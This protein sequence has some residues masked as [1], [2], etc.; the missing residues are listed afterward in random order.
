MQ[1]SLFEDVGP[2]ADP[3]RVSIAKVA[4]R[5]AK[6]LGYTWV[7]ICHQCRGRLVILNTDL[8]KPRPIFRHDDGDERCA[9]VAFAADGSVM[10]APRDESAEE[11]VRRTLRLLRIR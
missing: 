9:H 1:P 7:A 11:M 4:A 2:V 8:D 6:R 5:A 3:I 10:P